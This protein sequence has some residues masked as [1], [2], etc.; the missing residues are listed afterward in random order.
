[1]HLRLSSSLDTPVIED[2]TEDV[3]G[4]ICG[5]LI[6]PDRA[7]IEGFMLRPSGLFFQTSSL[8]LSRNDILH[9][10]RAIR[11]RDHHALTTPDDIVRLQPL[12]QDPRTVLGQ[13][14]RMEAGPALGRCRDVQFSTKT[15]MVEWMFPRRFWRWGL[16]IPVSEVLEIRPDAI[17][18]RDPNRPKEVRAAPTILQ[19]IETLAE[20]PPLTPPAPS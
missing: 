14:I 1:M 13:T 20:P 18:I 17:I 9:W 12:L 7:I 19:K 8:F 11:V 3:L 16:P 5:A 6:D 4:V 2:G 15:F 10:G